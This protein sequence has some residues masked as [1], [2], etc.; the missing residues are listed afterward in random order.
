MLQTVRG[1]VVEVDARSSGFGKSRVGVLVRQGNDYLRAMWFNQPFMRE[2][3][4]EGQHVLLSAKPRLR[5]GRW[6]MAHPRVTWLDGADDQPEMRLLPLYPLTEGLTQYQMRRMVAGGGRA[7]SAACWKK[8]FRQQLLAEYDL[9]PLAEALPAIHS[10]QDAEQL[11]RARRRFVFQELFVLQ[12]AVVARRW[13]QQT[14]LSCA[15][16]GGDG[17]DQRPDRAAVSV[18]IDGRP[19]GG[20]PRGGRR[21]GHAKR[22]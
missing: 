7:S 18:R 15:A 17:R 16:A 21:H 11:A 19:A 1:E 20:D 12:L 5:G 8:F 13:Q 4:R 9:M 10:P 14:R 6:E 3:F 22:R 2:K